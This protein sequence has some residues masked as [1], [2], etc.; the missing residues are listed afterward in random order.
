MLASTWVGFIDVITLSR[1]KHLFDRDIIL[2]LPN[3][4]LI[5]KVSN[6]S[7]LIKLSEIIGVKYPK[8]FY[9]FRDTAGDF[10]SKELFEEES[11]ELPVVIKGVSDA[12]KPA[13]V[14]SEES[15]YDE[16]KRRREFIIQE[17]I[18]GYGVGYFAI[19]KDG[20]VLVEYMHRRIIE[21]KPSGGPSIC[22]CAY[23]DDELLR[24]GRRIIRK[25]N[26]TGMMMA[27][28][29]RHEET[30]EYYLMELNPK[31]WGSLELCLAIGLDFPRYLV[32]AFLEGRKDFPKKYKNRCF[33]WL[34]PGIH[35]LMIDYKRYLR[36]VKKVLERKSSCD[37][38]FDDMPHLLSLVA[39]GISKLRK[40][41]KVL[42]KFIMK[43]SEIKQEFIQKLKNR[44]IK[45]VI[46]D[47]DGVIIRLPVNWRK[48]RKELVSK[49]LI[50]KY[51]S[52]MISLYK[53]K[54]VDQELFNKIHS[55][56]EKYE[57]EAIKKI[58]RDEQMIESL[59]N[60]AKRGFKLALVSK[61]SSRVLEEVLKMFDLDKEFD[62]VIGRE[63]IL[64][65]E[66]QIK[67][68]INLLQ[69]NSKDYIFVGDS[70]SDIV[71]SA[72]TGLLPCLLYTSPSP[73]DLSTSRM[74]SSA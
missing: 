64:L 22:A 38:H 56:V 13:Y 17:F 34:F 36:M 7:Y 63:K 59:K 40:Y 32:E 68:V 28:F 60:L 14:F 67:Y 65:R 69:G 11:I 5:L 42:K 8:T 70:L 24:I 45:G 33:S 57:L 55:I 6:K 9:Y 27:E 21:E 61:Q 26:W 20:E 3:Y 46:F 1:H 12:S 52:I 16:I 44:R 54:L 49:G 25:L 43:E 31:F 72:R 62:V 53:A 48:V 58:R 39:Y 71:A 37:I 15:L 23:Y 10:R 74:P 73:R 35:Y 2:P 4:E 29:R 66:E 41:R 30:G 47:F 18:P 51:D 19:A 50:K